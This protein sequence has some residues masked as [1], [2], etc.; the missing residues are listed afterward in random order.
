VT[1][2]GV[3]MLKKGKGIVQISVSDPTHKLEKLL[4]TLDGNYDLES[5]IA[6]LKSKNGQSVVDINL[7]KGG[8]AGKTVQLK[9]IVKQS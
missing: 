9:L 6:Q 3:I 2:T 7:P 4:L 8:E 5:T 1:K